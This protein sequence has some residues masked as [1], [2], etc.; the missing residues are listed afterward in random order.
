VECDL[1]ETRI[2]KSVP[3]HD[4]VPTDAGSCLIARLHQCAYE[5]L[6]FSVPIGFSP[7]RFVHSFIGGLPQSFQ[8]WVTC[9][10]LQSAQ[11]VD[12]PNVFYST[13]LFRSTGID[14]YVTGAGPP[15]PSD[16]F[17]TPMDHV[18]KP[19]TFTKNFFKIAPALRW[20][21]GDLR[22][23]RANRSAQEEVN[24]QGHDST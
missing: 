18:I 19:V 4:L 5:V 6:T 9:T 1:W 16:R 13:T 21:N 17:T 14:P 10:P 22:C 8:F 15:G 23:Q 12:G 24:W 7:R 11:S 20:Q 2:D 3:P